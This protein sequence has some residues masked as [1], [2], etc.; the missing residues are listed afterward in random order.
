MF[1]FYLDFR[2]ARCTCCFHRYYVDTTSLLHRYFVYIAA[3]AML[4]QRV[5]FLE[6]FFFK[7]I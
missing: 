1:V 2:A 4:S 3:R 7:R 5:V 6:V